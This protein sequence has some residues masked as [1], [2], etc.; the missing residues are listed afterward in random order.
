MVP[1]SCAAKVAAAK[2]PILAADDGGWTSN[3]FKFGAG[4]DGGWDPRSE[5]TQATTPGPSIRI[6]SRQA[7]RDSGVPD[8]LG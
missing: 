1:A 7:R 4:R 3:S 2:R 6:S 5:W 8:P